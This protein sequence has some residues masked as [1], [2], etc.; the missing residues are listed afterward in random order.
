MSGPPVRARVS[1][2]AQDPAVAKRLWEE[3]AR[4]TGVPFT[5]AAPRG[6]AG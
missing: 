5:F 2:R 3:S 4:L 6:K 1:T